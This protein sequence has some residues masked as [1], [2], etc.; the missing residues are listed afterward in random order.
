MS[1]ASK[2]RALIFQGGWAGHYP[3]AWA[4]L[5]AEDL[6]AGGLEVEVIDSLE[7]LAQTEYLCEFALLVPCWTMGQLSPEQSAG[8]FQAVRSG[9]GLGGNHGGM[10]DAFRGNVKYE[11]MVGGHFLGHPYVGPYTVEVVDRN[12]VITA[13]LPESFAYD[14][15]QYYMAVDPAVAVLAES[16]YTHEGQTCRMPVAWT[17]VWGAGRV[18]YCALGHDPSEFE[19]HPAARE[20]TR[21]GLLWA[22]NVEVL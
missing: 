6:I 17:K 4:K 22:A 5:M 18:F 10:G 15:E 9:V 2:K 14:S 1:T 21:R 7:P 16:D 13:G 11:W 12:H 19:R 20:L 8:L 3:E